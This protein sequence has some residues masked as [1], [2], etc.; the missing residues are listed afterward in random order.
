MRSVLIVVDPPIF[1][2]SSGVRHR[3]E[4]RRIQALLPEPAVERFDEGVIG[5]FSGP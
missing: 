1:D 5:R 4:P 2:P 3:Q